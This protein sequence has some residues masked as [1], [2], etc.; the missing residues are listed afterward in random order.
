M[1]RA[2]LE[3]MLLISK[4]KKR[5]IKGDGAMGT[6]AGEMAKWKKANGYKADKPKKKK[7]D[8]APVRKEEF[9]RRELEEMMGVRNPTYSRRR[10]AI[11]QR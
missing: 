10:G 9:S 11:R 7:K 2:I 4:D 1:N 8:P 5:V 3:R 6:L